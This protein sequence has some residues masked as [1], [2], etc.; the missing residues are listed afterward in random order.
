M[1]ALI[2][3]SSVTAIATT[4]TVPDTRVS[5]DTLP[6]NLNDLK[7]SS[8]AGLFLTNLITGSGTLTGTAGNDLI[9]GSSSIDVIDGLGGDDCIVGGGG[10]DLL[11]GGDGNDICLGG[12]G[13][14][15]FTTCEGE[16]Q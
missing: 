16:S 10:D 12:P 4:N 3:F 2:L 5:L 6:L 7:P 14:D 13:T 8:C 15:T 9:L 11:T 1:I